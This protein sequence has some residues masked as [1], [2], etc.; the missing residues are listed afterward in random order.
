MRWIWDGSSRTIVEIPVP[1]FYSQAVS[2]TFI[3]KAQFFLQALA[4]IAESCC[5]QFFYIY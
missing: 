2:T 1:L 5:G 3:A 4:G